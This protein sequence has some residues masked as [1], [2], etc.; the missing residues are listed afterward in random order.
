M[1]SAC[2]SHTSSRLSL[3]LQ[4]I[5]TRDTT[6]VLNAE[7]AHQPYIKS[8][9]EDLQ[10]RLSIY[11]VVYD[12]DD[13]DKLAARGGAGEN[14]ARDVSLRSREDV[15]RDAAAAMAGSAREAHESEIPYE[16]QVRHSVP[17]ES[18][19]RLWLCGRRRS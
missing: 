14:G 5:V 1:L 17:S 16:L 19:S 3:F 10:R 9:I 15:A 12:A 8:F 11:G 18:S 2:T 4:V 6:L 13:D 7:R